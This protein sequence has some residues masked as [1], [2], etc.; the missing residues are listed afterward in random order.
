MLF[1]IAIIVAYCFGTYLTFMVTKTFYW[2]C[3]DN[4]D[5]TMFSIF[6]PITIPVWAVVK[7]VVLVMGPFHR[8]LGEWLRELRSTLA[9]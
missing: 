8:K 5:V 1:E 9:K 7:L 6:W 2:S 3:C 4:L